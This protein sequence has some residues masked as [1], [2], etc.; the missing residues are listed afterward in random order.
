MIT[1]LEQ[2]NL[3]LVILV[4]KMNQVIYYINKIQIRIKQK[5]NIFINIIILIYLEQIKIR[6][7]K[8]VIFQIIVIPKAQI[9]IIIC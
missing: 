3:S 2:G 7:Q 6:I 9:T 8:K 4:I 5:I 1:A